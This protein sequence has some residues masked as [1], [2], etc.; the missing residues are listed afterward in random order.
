MIYSLHVFH[1]GQSSQYDYLLQAQNPVGILPITQ[2]DFLFKSPFFDNS[3]WSLAG[4]KPLFSLIRVTKIHPFSS[5]ITI[6]AT[7]TG[8]LRIWHQLFANVQTSL[9]LVMGQFMRNPSSI[10]SRGRVYWE[11]DCCC[12]AAEHVLPTKYEVLCSL[13]AQPFQARHQPS[14][15]KVSST[16][17]SICSLLSV[18][19]KGLKQ[20]CATFSLIVPVTFTPFMYFAPG[21]THSPF[22]LRWL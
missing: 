14:Q 11:V 22:C 16:L 3:F 20:F 18:S 5:P 2:Y 17:A 19:L 7:K 10:C 6:S 9:S 15:H 21:L 12:F 1:Q 8:I 4:R 13:V